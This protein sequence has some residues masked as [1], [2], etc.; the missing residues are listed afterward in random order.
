MTSVF[1]DWL[2]STETLLLFCNRY[3]ARLISFTTE[4][5]FL[6][7]SLIKHKPEQ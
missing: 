2:Q 7:L 5:P 6:Q 3:K 1:Q 4:V